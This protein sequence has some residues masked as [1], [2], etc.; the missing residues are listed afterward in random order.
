MQIQG[1]A[2][3]M[4]HFIKE[5][6]HQTKLLNEYSICQVPEI[7]KGNGRKVTAGGSI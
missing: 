4:T 7:Y 5:L 2:N 3:L 6:D 1:V